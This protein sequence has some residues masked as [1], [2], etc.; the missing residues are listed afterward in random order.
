MN[1]F[2][3]YHLLQKVIFRDM[4]TPNHDISDGDTEVFCRLN[5]WGTPDIAHELDLRLNHLKQ[6]VECVQRATS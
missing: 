4:L 6:L 2:D 3:L 5:I 1:K